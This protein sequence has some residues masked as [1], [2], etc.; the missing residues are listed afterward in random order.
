VRVGSAFGVVVS[1]RLSVAVFFVRYIGAN[2]AF[3]VRQ[4]ISAKA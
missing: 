3:C 2:E 4:P 1:C